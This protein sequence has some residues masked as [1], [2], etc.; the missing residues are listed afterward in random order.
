MKI[1]RDQPQ[2]LIPGPM[3]KELNFIR[4]AGVFFP[5]DFEGQRVYGVRVIVD[6]RPEVKTP[7]MIDKMNLL[8]R[9]KGGLQ[10]D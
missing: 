8:G 1:G 2:H 10:V 4:L 3:H 5:I 9:D 7:V 6:K